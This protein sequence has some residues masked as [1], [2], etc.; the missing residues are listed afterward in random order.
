MKNNTTIK[1][2][3]EKFDR[4]F[5]ESSYVLE[6]DE[7]IVQC[8][9]PYPAY[10]FIS[11][12]GRLFSVFGKKIVVLKPNYRKTGKKNHEGKRMGQ[13][14]Y[15]DTKSIGKVSMHKLIAEHFLI[16]EFESDEICEVHHKKKRSSFKENE[17]DQCNREDNLQ[18][19]PQSV[20]KKLTKFSSKTSQQY[21]EELKQ[22]VKNN[23]IP[24]YQMTQEGLTAFFM[25]SLQQYIKNSGVDPI[26]Y[27]ANL[28]DDVSEIEAEAHP[29]KLDKK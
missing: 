4:L 28:A 3:Q 11:N 24:V 9:Y 1:M 6:S 7:K 22:K 13:D 17:A 27:S 23:N 14:W 21:D 10:W 19:L 16:N 29:L 25:N 15:Y 2:Y 5:S 18:I 12:K 20:H 8:K 26:V